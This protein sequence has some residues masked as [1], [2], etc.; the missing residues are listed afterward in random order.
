M[1]GGGFWNRAGRRSGGNRPVTFAAKSSTVDTGALCFPCF[2]GR[3]AEHVSDCRPLSRDVCEC[4]YCV[5]RLHRNES[6]PEGKR[7]WAAVDRAADRALPR[8]QGESE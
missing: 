4:V 5:G 7:V 6:T 8:E 3:H 1:A 2:E